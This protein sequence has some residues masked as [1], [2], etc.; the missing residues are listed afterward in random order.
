MN[1]RAFY[2]G[3][4][5]MGTFISALSQVILKKAAQ[6]KYD[7]FLKSYLNFPVIFA[8]GLF[9]GTT[10]LSLFAYKVVPL[11]MGAIIQ[12]LNYGFILV[13]GQIFFN[14][15]ITLRKIIGVL[16]ILLGIYIFSI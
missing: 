8:Y 16:I 12:S 7:S 14:E 5:I 11:S 1:S 3:A 4:L 6:K 9:F 15:K 13:F 10:I 2:Y